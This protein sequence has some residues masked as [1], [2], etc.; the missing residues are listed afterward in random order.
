MDWEPF[1]AFPSGARLVVIVG[2][3]S[4]PGPIQ[5]EL[6]CRPTRSWCRIG[7]AR[8]AS[9]QSFRAFSTSALA[10]ISGSS[11][12]FVELPGFEFPEHVGGGRGGNLW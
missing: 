7:T 10:T 5:Q 9:T 6:K 8:I 2:K 4:E 11:K 3:P 1:A 12:I